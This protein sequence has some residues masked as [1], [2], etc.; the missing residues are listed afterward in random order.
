MIFPGSGNHFCFVL[1]CLVELD[2]PFS[3]IQLMSFSC[4]SLNMVMAFLFFS[5]SCFIFQLFFLSL[6]LSLLASS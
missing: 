1:I 6:F 2:C 4:S 3:I 5:C